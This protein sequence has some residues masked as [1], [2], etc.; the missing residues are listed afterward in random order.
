MKKIMM[1][2]MIIGAVVLTACAKTEPRACTLEYAPVCGIDGK[3]YGNRCMAQD[4]Q[5]AYIGECAKANASYRIAEIMNESCSQDMDCKTPGRYLMMSSC[6]YTS[7]CLDDKCTVVC[8]IY[9][10][11]TYPKVKEC[12]ECPQIHPLQQ[13]CKNGIIPGKIDECG[14]QSSP[15]CDNSTDN[16]T[17]QIANPASTFCVAHGG[18]LEIKTATDGSQTGYC[19]IKGVECEEWSLVRGECAGIHVCNDT[20][21]K[22]EICTLEYSPMCGSDN[23]TYGNKCGACAAGI[24]YAVVGECK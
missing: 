23:I 11:T 22:A 24:D 16:A 21:K 12:G 10:G 7:K 4:A 2:L 20:E 17:V 5:I 13:Y 15:R 18:K 3:T 8:P 19:T 14:C 9:N 1:I 6:P